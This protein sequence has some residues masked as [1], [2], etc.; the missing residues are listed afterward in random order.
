V[1]APVL[2]LLALALAGCGGGD[3]PAAPTPLQRE[4]R[5]LPDEMAALHP[6]VD[7]EVP[8]KEL[9]AE[10][11]ELAARAPDLTRAELTV[12]LMRFFTLGERDGHG[13]IFL[14][15]H[16]HAK[17]FSFF[18]LRVHDFADGVHVV[19]GEHR[20]KRVTAIDGVPIADVVEQVEPL[21]PR[22]NAST[23]RLLLPEY[24]VCAEVLRGLGIV[25]GEATYA[26]ADGSEVTLED[27]S[28]SAATA[29]DPLPL[30]GDPLLYRSLDEAFVLE[31]LDGG[32]ALYLGYHHVTS[33]PQELLDAILVA[34]RKP[35][36]RRLV[37]D[38]RHNGG[39]D[40]TTYWPLISLLKER[41][42][43]GKV[44][45][46]V[47]RMTFSAAGNFAASVDHETEAVIVGEPTGGAPNQWGDRIPIELA[48]AGLTAYVA[49]E[50]VEI[51][52]DDDRLAV[53]PDV[54]VEPTAADFLASRD[55]VLEKAL[56]LP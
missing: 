56:A 24:L 43:Q 23:V 55:P 21:I 52:P 44:A 11:N 35:G 20:G 13:G 32:R 25:D 16:A 2:A 7:H 45:L 1:R 36:F 33:P 5:A 3:E 42:L 41:P 22:D 50:W 29:F 46:L 14:H 19:D 27:A 12:G 31:P 8:L 15:D 34:A 26:F 47:G 37:I 30:E 4:L 39:G 40:N 53:E 38:V 10:A 49:A 28:G 6:E 9:R 54:P 48:A 17:P 18:P 51:A